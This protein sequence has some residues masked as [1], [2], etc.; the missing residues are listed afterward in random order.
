M[1]DKAD[2]VINHSNRELVY[3]VAVVYQEIDYF[4]F[5]LAVYKIVPDSSVIFKLQAMDY[6][7]NS[8]S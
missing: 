2:F 6:G 8:L 4:F 1:T 3:S 5:G 7:F